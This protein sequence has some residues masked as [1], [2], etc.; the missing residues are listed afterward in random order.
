MLN[1][2]DTRFGPDNIKKQPKASQFM[3]ATIDYN[4]EAGTLG[5]H[6]AKQVQRC[7]KKFRQ[8]ID[9]NF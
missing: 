7:I 1:N 2:L 4:H 6:Q 8:L 3:G 9:P 5:L